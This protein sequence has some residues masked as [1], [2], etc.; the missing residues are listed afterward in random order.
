VSTEPESRYQSLPEIDRLYAEIADRIRQSL[1]VNET[2]QTTVR[3]IRG[4]LQVDRVFVIQILPDGSSVIRAE[5]VDARY[6]AAIGMTFDYA[7]T[8]ATRQDFLEQPLRVA[9]DVTKIPHRGP[10]LIA[11]QKY[12]QVRSTLAM[13]LGR[14]SQ[15]YGLLVAQHCSNCRAWLEREVALIERLAPQV[16]LAIQQSEM[17]QRLQISAQTLEQTVEERTAS[18]SQSLEELT[19]ANEIK[20]QMIHALTHDLQTPLLGTVMFLTPLLKQPT[21]EIT[22]PRHFLERLLESQERSLALMR[23]LLQPDIPVETPAHAQPVNLKALTQNTLEPIS[24]AIAQHQTQIQLDFDENLPQV[25]GDPTQIKQV[26][27]TLILNALTHN[28]TGRRLVLSAAIPGGDRS[29]DYPQLRISV[30][31]N[32]QGLSVEQ[33]QQLFHRPYLRSNHKS[34]RTGLGLGLYLSARIIKAHGGEIG[35]ISPPN[36]GSTFWFT[37]PIAE[38]PAPEAKAPEQLLDPLMPRSA[39]RRKNKSSRMP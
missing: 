31:D 39:S 34:R 22:L 33:I 1:D 18:L 7:E 10:D 20:D 28:A 12:L 36:R 2:L 19:V 8:E 4:F 15:P 16:D 38:V 27:E 17:Y 23:S 13:I 37:L 35:V 26:L 25:L 3:E 32:G 11:F 9:E 21:P 5:S 14:P 29:P 6:P 24:A 30:Q